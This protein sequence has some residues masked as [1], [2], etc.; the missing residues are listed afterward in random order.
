MAGYTRQSAADIIPT[1][2][3]RAAPLNAE[4]DQLDSAF[5]GATGHTHDGT[6]GNG[7]KLPLTSAISGVLPIANGGTNANNIT[8]ARDNLGLE[9]G[10]DVQAFDAEL[11]AVAAL[12]GTGLV[13][14][15]G[16]GTMT[17]RTLI[18]PAAGITVTNG[19]GVS[20]NPTL[21]LANDLAAVEGL[22]STGIAVRT[23]A[24]T[25]AQR[26]I[27]APAAGITVTNPAGIAGDPTLVLANDL[28]ALEAMSGTGLAVHTGVSTWTERTLTG[29]ANEI[30]IANGTGVSGNPTV[31]LPAALTFTGKTV[32]GGTF[33]G[34]S[35]SFT[36]LTASGLLTTNGQISFPATANPSADVN[37]LDD[38]EEGSWT[39]VVRFGGA[40]VGIT[41]A[42]Q[43]GRYQKVGNKVT[44]WG[45]VILSSKGSSTG[46]M[47]MSGLP[48][49]AGT[50]IFGG[51]GGV[52]SFWNT[53]ISPNNV[54][55][56][57]CSVS[58]G[59]TII[60]FYNLP[61]G[62]WNDVHTTNTNQ[63]MFHIEYEV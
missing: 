61:N 56:T 19:N 40:S 6:T 59:T 12:S 36:T 7:P 47:T 46:T 48:F 62:V 60:N 44:I 49:T 29:T 14:H 39:P 11:A 21:V 51:Y 63:W 37:T 22:G 27:V 33:T 32:T 2:V 23:A 26:S 54:V 5:S 41:Y 45:N 20:G 13:A 4:F 57:G 55:S 15:T 52:V 16:A 53:S 10:V 31:S 38:Y 17:E 3:V 43:S 58:T 34:G 18:A 30:D 35:G 9:I 28:A 50:G 24:D 25:W 42:T 1:A 8:S